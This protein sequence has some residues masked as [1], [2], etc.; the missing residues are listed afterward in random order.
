ME[1][2]ITDGHFTDIV[3]QGPPK[4]GGVP[5]LQVDELEGPNLRPPEEMQS[6]LLLVY[7]DGPSRN[8]TGGLL[9]VTPT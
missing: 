6:V 8:N 5:G 2:L 4:S 9:D 7:L 1:E 3:L